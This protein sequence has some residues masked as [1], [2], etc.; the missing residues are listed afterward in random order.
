[1]ESDNFKNDQNYITPQQNLETKQDYNEE[2]DIEASRTDIEEEFNKRPKQRTCIVLTVLIALIYV[3]C[4]I[5]TAVV[6]DSAFHKIKSVDSYIG[7][8][9]DSE[10]WKIMAKCPNSDVSDLVS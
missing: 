3:A 10:E 1:M 4:I 7:K 6:A 2:H 9:S 5:T 8:Y